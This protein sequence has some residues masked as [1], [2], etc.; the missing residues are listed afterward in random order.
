M[1]VD[2]APLRKYRDFR[3]LFL[4]QIVSFF[5]SMISYVAIPYQV[6][7]L[8][9]SSLV[10]GFLGAAQLLPVVIFGLIGG[11]VADSMDRR[12]LLLYSEL[13]MSLGALGLIV[14]SLYPSPSVAVIF[15]IAAFMQAANGFH[16]PAM[17]AISQKLVEAKDY[18]A[19]AALNT[20]RSTVGS[21]AGPA[22]GGILIASGGSALA[23]SVDLASFF[24]AMTMVY[25]MKPQAVVGKTGQHLGNILE[26]LHYAFSRPVLLGTY[27]IDIVAMTFAFPLALFPALSDNWGGAKAAGYLYAAM[28]VG[29]LGVALISAWTK[30]VNRHGAAVVISATGWG[31]AIIALGYAPSLQL[32][33]LALI[34][35]GITDGASGL[36]RGVI[37]NET[38]PNTMRGR[39]AGLEMISYMTG[40]LLGNTRAGWM[41]GY[42]GN[43]FSIVWGGVL[44]VVGVVVTAAFLPI[45]WRYRS[46]DSQ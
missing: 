9:K 28:S 35:A 10:V 25:L 26:G 21:I 37:W 20:I 46:G 42:G 12:K 18:P 3:L 1:F 30:N 34:F 38:V 4:G 29:A 8:T 44:C 13:F 31:I 33:V 40:P 39:L 27:I 16:R 24:F 43:Q 19:V 2:L 36:F 23:Y 32:A 17:E 14:N 22:M 7:Q 11:S 45:F 5:G 15:C 41:A 6:Y